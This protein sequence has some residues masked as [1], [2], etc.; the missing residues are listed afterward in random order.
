[1]E[2]NNHM[3][4]CKNFEIVGFNSHSGWAV[5]FLVISHIFSRGRN[6]F[7]LNQALIKKHLGTPSSKTFPVGTRN[8]TS[9]LTGA[10]AVNTQQMYPESIQ[11]RL[12]VKPECIQ[13]LSQCKNHS[14]NLLNSSNHL[15]DAPDFRVP[16]DRKGLTHFWAYP[17]NNY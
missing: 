16:Y 8:K 2:C 17:P 14:I 11:S 13:S 7:T 9:F 4:E 12:V 1:M 15:W 5:I 10:T 6:L 3:A